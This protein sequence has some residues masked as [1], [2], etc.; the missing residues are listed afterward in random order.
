MLIKQS[1][2]IGSN[3]IINKQSHIIESI[4]N[5]SNYRIYKVK[6]KIDDK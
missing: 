1:H 2:I 5:K 4:H 3:N 6:S